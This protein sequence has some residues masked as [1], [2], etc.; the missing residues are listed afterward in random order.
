MNT[1][2]EKHI[3]L[4][5]ETLDT[6]TTAV[7]PS[8]GAVEFY[9]SLCLQTHQYKCKAIQLNM[10]DIED[11]IAKGRT[12]SFSTIKWWMKQ[13]KEAI[14]STFEPSRSVITE[15][16]L[17][18]FAE[19]CLKKN[20]IWIGEAKDVYIWGNGN[21]FDNAIIRSMFDTYGMSYPVPFRNDFD[22]RTFRWLLKDIEANVAD[23][24]ISHNAVDDAIFQANSVMATLKNFA[25]IKQAK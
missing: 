17:E 9:P 19:F 23:A 18:S 22:L 13:S 2:K 11:Q 14:N 7:V 15:E 10:H 1:V 24:G 3:M 16:A 4:D 6:K 12:T 8:I 5:I 25:K 21:M 20:N